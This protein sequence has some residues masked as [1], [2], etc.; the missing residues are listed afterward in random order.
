[1][2]NSLFSLQGKIILVTGASSG[3]GHTVAKG[4][5]EAGATLAVAARRVDKLQQLV[6]DIE[7]QGGKALAVSMDVTE[8][9]SITR[10]FD[11]AQEQLGVIDTVINNAGVADTKPFL[12]TDQHSLDFV[13]STNFEGVWHVAQEASQRMVDA[14]CS[15]SI[16]NISSYLGTMNKSGYTAYCASKGAVNQLTRCMSLDLMKHG[17][18]VNGI[19]PGWFKTEINEHY[20]DSPQGMEYIKQMP[21]RRLGRTEELL[22]PIIMLASKAGSFVNGVIVPVDGAMQVA[23]I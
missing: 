4:L 20:F 22:G 17:I 7:Q 12:K 2:T 15:G 6:A 16:I 11:Q 13:M 9:D 21:A 1:M 19:A 3:I 8:R 5:A 10:A 14:R 23:G 18:R